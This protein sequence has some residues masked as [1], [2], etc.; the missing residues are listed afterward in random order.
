MAKYKLLKNKVTGERSICVNAT[1]QVITEK[2]NPVEYADL[3]KKAI[4]NMK[5]AIKHD[6]LT[7]LGLTR[8]RGNLGGTYYE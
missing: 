7:S 3:R 6:A 2:D 5:Q 4:N 8:V 1:G